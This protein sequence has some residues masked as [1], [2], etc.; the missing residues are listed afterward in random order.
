MM[1]RVEVKVPCKMT[2]RVMSLYVVCN[3]EELDVKSPESRA[4]KI[5]G[6]ETGA[7]KFTEHKHP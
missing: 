2:E 1:R 7:Q 5:R 3:H 6:H 4:E